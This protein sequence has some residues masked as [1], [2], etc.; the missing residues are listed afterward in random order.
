MTIYYFSCGKYFLKLLRFLNPY[1]NTDLYKTV[2]KKDCKI[3]Y[4]KVVR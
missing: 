4:F 3:R 2:F 1:Q